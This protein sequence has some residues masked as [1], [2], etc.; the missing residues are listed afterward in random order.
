MAS[1]GNLYLNISPKLASDKEDLIFFLCVLL[2]S[3]E[4]SGLDD[5]AAEK[6]H[7]GFEV[8]TATALGR[9]GVL[10]QF[11]TGFSES[12]VDGFGGDAAAFTIQNRKRQEEEG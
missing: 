1:T 9:A 12:P 5:D 2:F 6:V 8:L 11:G 3:Q 7:L 10:A 4:P